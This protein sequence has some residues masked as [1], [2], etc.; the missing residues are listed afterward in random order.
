MSASTANL[1]SFARQSAF[2]SGIR[3]T[4]ATLV[5]LFIGV[6]TGQ[7][8]FWLQVAIGGLLVS[9]ADVGGT[10]R[11]KAT[12]MIAATI[13]GAITC[14]LGTL[15]GSSIWL[16]V[17]LMF[18]VAFCGGMTNAFGNQA[19][20]VGTVMVM[21]F[22]FRLAPP[23]TLD[24]GL[25]RAIGFLIGGAWAMALSLW[26]WPTRPYQVAAEAIEKFYRQLA[27]YIGAVGDG[28]TGAAST[29]QP[30]ALRS[31]VE[32]AHTQARKAIVAVRATLTGQNAIGQRLILLS[33][34]GDS[35][36]HAVV[37]LKEEAAV[38]ASHPGFS[39]LAPK[40]RAFT[41]AL[42]A[43]TDQ[44]AA[45]VAAHGGDVDGAV[46]QSAARNVDE[47][48]TAMTRLSS[49]SDPKTELPGVSD[50]RNLAQACAYA[51]ACAQT[52]MDCV[53]V[54]SSSEHAADGIA[55]AAA[56]VSSNMDWRAVASKIRDNLTLQSLPF[57][58]ALRLAVAV[59]LG[60]F[61]YKLFNS[62]H[63]YWLP[64]A[65]VMIMKPN[66]GATR[67]RATEAA[68]GTV[69]GGA[70]ATALSILVVN[71]YVQ[72]ALM[73]P[74]GVIA[75]AAMPRSYVQYVTLFTPFFILMIDIM[76]PGNWVFGLE[77]IGYMIG[78]AILSVLAA[79]LL[80]PSWERDQLPQQLGRTVNANRAYLSAVLSAY[81]QP[82]G[83]TAALNETLERANLENVN[84]EAS[85]Q[86]LVNEPKSQQGD[87]APAY[88]LVTYN[89]RIFD[90][91]TALAMRPRHASD[92][93][94]MP[95]LSTIAEQMDASLGAIAQALQT[96]K[97]APS[98]PA[99]QMTTLTLTVTVTSDDHV[100]P[101]AAPV[102]SELSRLAQAITDMARL[103]AQ[104]TAKAS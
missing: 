12:V 53:R 78:G 80:W 75:F 62:D 61:I 73:A 57:R 85:F 84:A 33:S 95:G 92:K 99:Q 86:R 70:I 1:L 2:A 79:N 10:S 17:P 67:K 102:Q 38:A 101:D 14:V 6:V 43:A 104:M 9:S 88:A 31:A 100:T 26:L 29:P 32:A 87:I 51:A 40:L 63:G 8:G 34:S 77:R 60:V 39:A 64:L 4:A 58:H 81:V 22:V 16:A 7:I 25:E 96:G 50:L 23:N 55:Q 54:R 3:S 41:Q 36:F 98:V 66:F 37:G 59:S 20:S 47:A 15:A 35:L 42:S 56:P 68:L 18:A 93:I 44:I 72:M 27:V 46:V 71:D 28:A 94:A 69:I 65:V 48:L 89:Q 74:L 19:T 30:E 103:E 52:A 24:A 45:A 91:I 90:G 76:S 13:A 97:S 83:D 49:A 5:P 21:A 82:P 11:N